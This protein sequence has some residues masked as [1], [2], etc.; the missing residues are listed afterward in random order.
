MARLFAL[1]PSGF[2]HERVA[3][4]GNSKC[5]KGNGRQ[6]VT[7]A[8]SSGLTIVG[9]W[10]VRVDS[11]TTEIRGDASTRQRRRPEEGL[12]YAE[13]GPS[14]AYLRRVGKPGPT[15]SAGRRARSNGDF[16]CRSR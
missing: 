11:E 2:D 9:G 16:V 5:P 12:S 10:F 15:F 14:Q 8:A 13:P 6:T 1:K 3:F 4:R 7:V